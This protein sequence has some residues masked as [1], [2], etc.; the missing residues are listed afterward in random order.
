MAYFGLADAVDTAKTLLDAIGVPRQVIVHHQVCTLEVDALAG[1]VR[2]QQHLH[3]GA[4]LERFLRLHAL[5]AA[6][7]ESTKVDAAA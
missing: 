7:A 3:F 5:L 1:G 6:Q 2:G 4:V